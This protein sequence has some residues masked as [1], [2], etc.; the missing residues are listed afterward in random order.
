MHMTPR[1]KPAHRLA[2]TATAKIIASPIYI[3]LAWWL[4]PTTLYNLKVV[5]N[6]FLRGADVLEDRFGLCDVPVKVEV[7]WELGGKL[8]QV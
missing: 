6:N 5:G 4:L 7:R 1:K 3:P 2:M 8:H